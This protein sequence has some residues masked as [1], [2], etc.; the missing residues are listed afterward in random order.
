MDWLRREVLYMGFGNIQPRA[1]FRGPGTADGHTDR[2]NLGFF[3]PQKAHLVSSLQTQ[4]TLRATPAINALL[5][6]PFVKSY[7]DFYLG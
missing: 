1:E 7:K 2:S 6:L 5:V 4:V 3:F